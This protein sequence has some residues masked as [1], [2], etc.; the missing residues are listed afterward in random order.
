MSVGDLVKVHWG[1]CDHSGDQG[2]D[3]GYDIALVTGSVKWWN[4]TVQ[5]VVPCGDAEILFRG[6]RVYYNIGRL[7]VINASG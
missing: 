2:V 3:W 6:E 4:D 1:N 7:E 5:G